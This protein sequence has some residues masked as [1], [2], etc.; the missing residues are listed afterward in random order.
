MKTV[1]ERIGNLS[2]ELLDNFINGAS[3]ISCGSLLCKDCP[4]RT[5]DSCIFV[6]FYCEKERRM[7]RP[8][9]EA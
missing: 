3:T 5:D 1:D 8:T 9:K 2:D 4:V 7:A 6:K